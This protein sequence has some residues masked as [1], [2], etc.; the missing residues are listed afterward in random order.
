MHTGLEL[1]DHP[2]NSGAVYHAQ[3]FLDPPQGCCGYVDV[4]TCQG[5]GCDDARLMQVRMG[6]TTKI[7]FHMLPGLWSQG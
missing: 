7:W 6:M 5:G 4:I 3:T 2:S 1:V